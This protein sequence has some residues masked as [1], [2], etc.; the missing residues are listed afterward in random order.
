MAI[1]EFTKVANYGESN[2]AEHVC[3]ILKE[4]DIDAFVDGANANSMMSHVGTALGGVNLYVRNR[5]AEQA[6]ILIDELMPDQEYSP[7][8]F[9][10]ACNEEV[11]GNFELCWSCGGLRSEVEAVMPDLA[12][13]ADRHFSAETQAEE[14]VQQTDDQVR[15]P[16][17]APRTA[18]KPTEGGEAALE[19]FDEEADDNV[20]RAFRA[21]VVGLVLLPIIAH[22]YSMYLLIKASSGGNLSSRGSTLFLWTIVINVLSVVIW[23]YFMSL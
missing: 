22:T 2:I 14:L 15:N 10:G 20:R 4:N 17:T 13:V 1:S 8:W 6:K 3:S 21:S 19:I 5:D 12:K 7:P 23:G 16:Y 18:T 11:E 9:C